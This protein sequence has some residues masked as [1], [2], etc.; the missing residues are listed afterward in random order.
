M[1]RLRP[2]DGRSTDAEPDS[3]PL[4]GRFA[5]HRRRPERRVDSIRLVEDA[6]EQVELRMRN[7]RRLAE[8]FNIDID[9]GDSPRAA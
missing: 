6:L 1:T 4:A 5:E 8:Q 7:L 2:I 9:G 3:Y